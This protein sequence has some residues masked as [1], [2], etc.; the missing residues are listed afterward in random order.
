MDEDNGDFEV[1]IPALDEVNTVCR[2][3]VC[4]VLVG[5]KDIRE[6]VEGMDVIVVLRDGLVLLEVNM[7]LVVLSGVVDV[8]V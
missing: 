4:L 8:L 1:L 2:V 3:V 5:F 7:D 6:V